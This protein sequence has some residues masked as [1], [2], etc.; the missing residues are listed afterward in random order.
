MNREIF[1]TLLERQIGR[2]LSPNETSKITYFLSQIHI[3]GKTSLRLAYRFYLA[4]AVI[5][6]KNQTEEQI[7]YRDLQIRQ[8]GTTSEDGQLNTKINSI[9][10]SITGETIASIEAVFLAEMSSAYNLSKEVVPSSKEKYNYLLLDS[11]NAYEVSEDRTKFT[12]LVQEEKLMILPGYINLHAKLR[13]I[14]M[15][16]LGRLSL[17]HLPVDTKDLLIDHRRVGIGFEEFN[18]QAIIVPSGERFQFVSF[19][20]EY[21]AP[22]GTNLVLS[23]FFSNR[24]WFRFRENYKT[25]DKL[26]CSLYD[27]FASSK[28]VFPDEYTTILGTFE[29]TTGFPSVIIFARPLSELFALRQDTIKYIDPSGADPVVYESMSISG[30][31][32]DDPVTDAALI[33]SVNASF[34][35][36]VQ[37]GNIYNL[38]TPIDT[39]GGTYFTDPYHV[40]VTITLGY[41]P[42]FLAALELVSE[43]DDDIEL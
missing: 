34:T 1:C 22:Y 9:T 21:D 30:F 18:S 40:T 33:A 8:L 42:R 2:R 26:T 27:L 16:R 11:R 37:A 19:F 39:T 17:T 29:Q 13:N 35:N 20:Q 3:N 38:Y 6:L 10:D 15:A 32:T 41:K 43:D 5:L 25:L 7:D 31:T 24:G 14:K 36:W 28:L 23:S 12:W 4:N